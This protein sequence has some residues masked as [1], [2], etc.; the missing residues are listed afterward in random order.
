MT[1]PLTSHVS[2]RWGEC[3][4]AGVVFYPRFFDWM[5]VVA[6]HL[7]TLIGI[8]RVGRAFSR[9]LPLVGASADY[10]APA[11]AEDEL[12]IAAYVTA[13][14]R[15]SISLRHEFVR[16]SDGVLLARGKER[17]V[18]VEF[19]SDGAMQPLALTDEM[20]TALAPHVEAGGDANDLPESAKML[21][22][23]PTR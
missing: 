19:S 18:L 2:V 23:R 12:D 8:K 20:R 6:D 15:T 3:D 17:R 7:H 21:V 22:A 5:D 14:G 11:F 4:P 1:T 10:L 9:G 16:R 13:L